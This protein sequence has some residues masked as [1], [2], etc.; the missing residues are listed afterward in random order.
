MLNFGRTLD[1]QAEEAAIEKRAKWFLKRKDNA[2]L[3]ES[4]VSQNGYSGISP[5]RTRN[6]KEDAPKTS[7][8]RERRRMGESRQASPDCF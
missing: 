7:I 1:E 5:G 4:I 2:R 3:L 6:L 8:L